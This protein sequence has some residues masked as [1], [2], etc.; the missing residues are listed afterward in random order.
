M[1][2]YSLHFVIVATFDSDPTR[3]IH[4]RHLQ[5][6]HLRHFHS[7]IG[8]LPNPV[9][10]LPLSHGTTQIKASV[11]LF[12]TT[13]LDLRH[14]PWPHLARRVTSVGR[15]QALHKY[16]SPRWF[17]GRFNVTCLVPTLY[18]SSRAAHRGDQTSKIWISRLD[19]FSLHFF[20]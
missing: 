20:E 1:T 19:S 13:L 15:A 12:S 10:P 16:V 14:S 4:L 11:E 9:S 17:A 7:S 5:F 6:I 3:T 8:L 18:R 2:L